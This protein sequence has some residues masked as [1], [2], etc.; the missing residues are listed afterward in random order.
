MHKNIKAFRFYEAYENRIYVDQSFQR[1]ACWSIQQKRRFILSLNKGRVLSPIVVACALTGLESSGSDLSSKEKYQKVLNNQKTYVS[2]DGQ[3]RSETIREFFND[4]L[5]I[6]G[7]FTDRDGKTVGVTN[8]TFNQLPHRL[9]DALK[10]ANIEMKNLEDIPYSELNDIFLSIND[11]QPLNDQEKRNAINTPIS[12]WIR[13]HSEKSFVDFWPMIQGFR[14]KDIKRFKDVECLIS[15]YMATLPKSTW[16]T[17]TRDLNNFYNL[18][19]DK[20]MKQ[21]EEYR[22]TNSRRFLQIM[23]IVTHLIEGAKI[24]PKYSNGVSQKL[25][26]GLVMFAEYLW[27][28]N[29]I[30]ALPTGISSN[31]Y[32]RLAELVSTLDDKLSKDE[33]KLLSQHKDDYDNGVR[34]DEPKRNQYYT[35]LQ[36]DHKTH[37]SRSSRKRKLITEI[38]NSQE[39][40]AVIA[41]EMISDD[42]SSD[43][44]AA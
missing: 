27:E 36:S 10:D 12:T 6:S 29:V 15:I 14:E 1:R 8:L 31:G 26:W 33:D 2:L 18:G 20:T 28:T 22:N 4:Q 5:A 40:N 42:E 37:T 39:Y 41:H 38:I 24:L 9:K 19:R 17:K 25:L 35:F 11:G 23:K 13:E 16:S 30:N 7:N 3:N 34:T 44:E 21:V 43:E 32:H